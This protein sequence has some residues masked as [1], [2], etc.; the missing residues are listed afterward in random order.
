MLTSSLSSS[1]CSRCRLYPI[2]N[3]GSADASGS[4]GAAAVGG[5]RAQHS[6]GEPVGFLPAIKDSI[7]RMR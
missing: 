4:G 6:Q 5:E 3:K 1:A 7:L 2:N